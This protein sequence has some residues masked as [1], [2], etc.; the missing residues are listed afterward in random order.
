M[1]NS[2]SFFFLFIMM[3]LEERMDFLFVIYDRTG[4]SVDK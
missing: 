2:G 3:Q 4:L 1:M